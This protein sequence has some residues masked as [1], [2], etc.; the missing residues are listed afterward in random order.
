MKKFTPLSGSDMRDLIHLAGLSQ[1][2]FADFVQALSGCPVYPQTISD[3][4]RGKV[5]RVNPFCAALLRVLTADRGGL[6]STPEAARIAETVDLLARGF[7]AECEDRLRRF[8]AV[9]TAAAEPKARNRIDR[10][11]SILETEVARVR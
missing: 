7:D 4:A 5:S 6:E 10:A 2:D 8:A 11:L 3:M 9:L 1:V